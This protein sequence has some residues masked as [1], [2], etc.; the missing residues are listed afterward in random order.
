MS[1]EKQLKFLKYLCMFVL[2]WCMAF[3]TQPAR[4]SEG[5]IS[6]HGHT[7]ELNPYEEAQY[8]M[9]KNIYFEA[10][11]QPVAGKIA[12]AQVVMNRVDNLHYPETVCEVVYQA[13]WKENWKGN[14][15]PIRY[16]CQFSWF[17]DGLSDEPVDS[18]TW[19]FSLLI[20]DKILNGNYGDITEGSTHYHNDTVHPYWA[21]SL[22]ETVVIN[23][24][25]FYK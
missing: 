23:N 21:D 6:W 9:A 25:I 18:A 13:Q 8:C 19:M 20:A 24:H 3:V 16:K 4:G 17:C 10:G 5:L 7:I 12:V 15:I 11:N 1:Q 22:N 2:G 14:L